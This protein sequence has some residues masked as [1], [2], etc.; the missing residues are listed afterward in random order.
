MAPTGQSGEGVLFLNTLSCFPARV[1]LQPTE[2]ELRACRPLFNAQ[3]AYARPQHILALGS[4]ALAA[5]VPGAVISVDR[6][7]WIRAKGNWGEAWV[8]GTYHPAWA[9]RN[10][11]L[12]WIPRE[13][14]AWFAFGT[15]WGVEEGMRVEGS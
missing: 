11:G 12:A 3:L 8:L 15:L 14:V 2:E 13:D 5:L 10:P 6:G 1:D 7:K 9:L 4:T